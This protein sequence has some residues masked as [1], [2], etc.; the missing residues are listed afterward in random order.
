MILGDLWVCADTE[1]SSKLAL[2]RGINELFF[3]IVRLFIDV[4]LIVY[5]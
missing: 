5:N 3:K 2:H 1:E 4:Q